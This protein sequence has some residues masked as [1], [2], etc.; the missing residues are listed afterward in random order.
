MRPASARNDVRQY[1]GLTDEWWRADS[2]FAMLRWL[3]AA[4]SELVPRAGRPGAVLV[5]LGCGGG[6]FAP[7]ALRLGYRPIGI[8]LVAASLRLSRSHGLTPV[9]A[10]V[11]TIPLGDGCADVVCAG[12]ILEHVRDPSTVVAEACRILRPGGTLVIDCINR[13][14]TARFLAITVAEWFGG[15]VVRGIHD[16]ELLVLP[17]LVVNAGARHGVNLDVRGV[18]PAA[19]QLLRWLVTRRGDVRIVPTMTSAVLYQAWGVKEG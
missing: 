3:A 17:A 8:D 11:A 5:D 10:D 19:G 12:Q 6:V 16:P 2:P 4:R 7:H 1:E 18:R 9:R 13:T 15:E 14:A